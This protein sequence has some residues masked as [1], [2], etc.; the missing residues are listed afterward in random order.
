MTTRRRLSP[1]QIHA[2]ELNAV[3]LSV[4]C[5]VCKRPPFKWC[6]LLGGKQL[7]QQLHTG[8]RPV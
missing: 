8:R 7:S 6:V 3:K 2:I 5:P 4:P 1:V